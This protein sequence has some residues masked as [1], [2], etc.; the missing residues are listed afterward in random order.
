MNSRPL[1]PFLVSLLLGLCAV[2][3]APALRAQ[4]ST[5]TDEL[6]PAALRSALLSDVATQL[7]VHFR[8]EGELQLE[9]VRPLQLPDS[10]TA[11]PVEI[12]EFPATLSSSM[13]VRVRVGAADPVEQTLVVRARLIREVWATRTPTERD[14]AFDASKLDTRRV[15]VLR[16]RDSVPAIESCADYTFNRPVPANRI[17]NWHDLSRRALVRRGQVIEVAAIDGTLSITMKALAMENGAAGETVK[18][19]NMD[20]KKEFNALVVADSR[21]QIRF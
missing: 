12:A 5:T 14:G 3:A 4:A 13:I 9:T 8:T 19:R 1:A 11:L 18:V 21:A 15:D 6:S 10:A 7:A 16:E 2:S 20:S 17:L